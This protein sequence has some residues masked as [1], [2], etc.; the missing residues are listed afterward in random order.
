VALALPGAIASSDVADAA[1]VD[2]GA[3][4]QCD[5]QETLCP[6]DDLEPREQTSGLS[7]RTIAGPEL[8]DRYPV[9]RFL[10]TYDRF[11][12]RR[13][14]PRTALDRRARSSRGR[15]RA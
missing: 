4:A 10:A 13:G 12:V 6:D 14:P 1:L 15:L 9:P 5:A 11:C 7:P 3:L 8:H 2:L